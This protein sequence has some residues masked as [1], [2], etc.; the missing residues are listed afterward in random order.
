MGWI[1]AERSGSGKQLSCPQPCERCF[2]FLLPVQPQGVQLWAAVCP[3]DG[4]TPRAAQLPSP[5]PLQ[6]RFPDPSVLFNV[7]QMR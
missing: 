1:P 6:L 5:L 3:E 2:T 4:A 7:S